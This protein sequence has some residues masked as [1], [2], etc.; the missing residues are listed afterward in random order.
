M[1]KNINF[2][3][4]LNIGENKYQLI[5]VRKKIIYQFFSFRNYSHNEIINGSKQGMIFKFQF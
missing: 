1:F 4:Q 5:F 3:F 2:F